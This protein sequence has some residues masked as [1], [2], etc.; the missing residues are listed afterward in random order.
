[1][2]IHRFFRSLLSA[3]VL[4]A[5]LSLSSCSSAQAAGVRQAPDF[6]VLD[7]SGRSVKL[8]DL[9]GRPVVI[10]FWAT[11]CPP[12]RAELPAFNKVAADLDGKI[13]FMMVD[14][15]DGGRETVERA[16]KFVAQEGYTF[17]VYFD[18][19]YEGAAAYGIRS[20]PTT[21]LVNSD[22]TISDAHI[23]AM[24]EDALRRLI[25]SLK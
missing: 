25:S 9:R 10:N 12:C 8:S 20:I 17:P 22:G 2:T 24:D 14:L 18:T 1:M 15:T 7:A 13:A 5:L 19:E 16:S 21:V 3:V 11:W 23:G 4:A 6:S